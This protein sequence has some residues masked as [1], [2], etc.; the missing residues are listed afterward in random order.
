MATQKPN[1]LRI[2]GYD[3]GWFDVGG[4]QRGIGGSLTTNIH[5]YNHLPYLSGESGESARHEFFD[6][7]EHDLC[8][9]RYNDWKVHF[10]TKNDWFPGALVKATEARPVIPRS[11]TFEQPLKTPD[12]PVYEGENLWTVMP[13]AATVRPHAATF[14]EFP[15]RQTPPDFYPQSMVESVIQTAATRQGN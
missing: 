9:V 1:I 14:K 7:G 3:V 10:R 2:M 15:P 4:C 11:D 13:A 12:H 8:A 5:G 6:Y